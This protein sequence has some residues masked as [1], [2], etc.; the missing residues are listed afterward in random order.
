MLMSSWCVII[1][2]I[3]LLETVSIDFWNSIEFLDSGEEGDVRSQ[4]IGEC[5]NKIQKRKGFEFSQ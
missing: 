5:K 3:L 4:F 2:I 1:V